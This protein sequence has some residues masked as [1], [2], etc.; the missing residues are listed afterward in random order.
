MKDKK[1]NKQKDKKKN[2][3]ATFNL[4]EVIIIIIMTSL[5]VGVSTGVVVYKNYNEIDKRTSKDEDKDYLK[6]LETAYKNILNSY[7]EKVDEKALTNAA[8]EAMY[9]HLGDPYTSYLDQDTA[10]DLMDRLNGEYSGIGVEIQKIDEGVLV[11]NIFDNSPAEK[12]GMLIGDL[13]IKINGEDVRNNTVKEV[14]EKI[15]TKEPVRITVYR[16]GIEKEITTKA[17]NVTITSVIKNN[18]EG[19]GYI[20]IST[21]SNNTYTQFKAALESLENEGINSLVIDVRNN[22][23]G[24]LSPAVEIAE[25][26]I[27]KG[28][29][30]YGL[31]SKETKEMYKD[32]TNDKRDYK[33]VILTNSA[34]ASAS[35]ILT[36]ALKES[37]GA[38]IVGT[39]T[40]GKGT[41]QET[42][43]LESG[44][45]VKYTTAYWLTPDG[46][47]INGIGIKPDFEIDGEENQFTEAIN[48]AK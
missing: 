30:I 36:A 4:I 41:V 16:S 38:I 20:K 9:R 17:Q 23:G 8:I 45:M 19:V 28:K 1:I 31:E 47:K 34:T 12:A 2:R 11:T 24:Y 43:T 6:E 21:F 48:R 15:K 29:N 3:T 37:Y 42:S 10:S 14:S 7:V 39:T 25:L 27:T 13:I 33:I 35:E 26:F 18:Y 5:I 44:G 40:Y 46:N 32:K 22:G